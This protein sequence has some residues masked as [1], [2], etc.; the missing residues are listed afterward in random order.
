[1]RMPSTGASRS[2]PT[3]LTLE[4]LVVLL[5]QLGLL[6]YLEVLRAQLDPRV[7]LQARQVRQAVLRVPRAQRARQVPRA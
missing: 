2:P 3:L 5:V 7:R 1:M 6:V 4:L